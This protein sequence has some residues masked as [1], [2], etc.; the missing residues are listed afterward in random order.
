MKILDEDIKTRWGVIDRVVREGDMISF[1]WDKELGVGG[2]IGA[3][4]SAVAWIAVNTKKQKGVKAYRFD[5]AGVRN[6]F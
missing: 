1:Q 4:R 5:E 3:R 2:R 6:A